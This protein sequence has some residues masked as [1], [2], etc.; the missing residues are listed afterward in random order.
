V[1]IHSFLSSAFPVTEVS[2]EDFPWEILKAQT[3]QHLSQELGLARGLEKDEAV[4]FL[5][6]VQ[7]KGCMCL[8]FSFALQAILMIPLASFS[9]VSNNNL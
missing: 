5:K 7:R 6:A 9:R 3:L 4:G 2:M 8:L 1:D